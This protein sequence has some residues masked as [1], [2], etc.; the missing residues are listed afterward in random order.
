MSEQEDSIHEDPLALRVL[1]ELEWSMVSHDGQYHYCPMCAVRLEDG[2]GHGERCDLARALALGPVAMEVTEEGLA[3][4]AKSLAVP[5]T[6]AQKLRAARESVVDAFELI[7]PLECQ[8]E[9]LDH[10][11]GFLQMVAGHLAVE[12]DARGEMVEVEEEESA[13]GEEKDADGNQ[14]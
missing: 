12:L 8:T 9:D 10:A 14:S 6:D 7:D 11:K 5:V 2:A 1:R 13:D 3:S 4:F